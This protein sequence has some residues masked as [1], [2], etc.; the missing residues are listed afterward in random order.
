[1]LSTMLVDL[2][3]MSPSTATAANNLTRCFMGAAGTAVVGLMVERMGKGW[4]FSFLAAVVFA[5]SPLLWV[6]TR[7]GPMWREERR[8]RVERQTEEKAVRIK[9]E[10]RNRDERVEKK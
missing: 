1:M 10:N 6:E 4:C 8:L 2:Y 3:P 5:A 9:K 7:W